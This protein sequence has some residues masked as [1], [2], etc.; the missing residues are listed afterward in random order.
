MLV[1]HPSPS[2]LL[3]QSANPTLQ[4]PLQTLLAH[5]GLAIWLLEQIAPH[6]LQLFLSLVVLISQ[7][8]VCLLPLQSAKPEAQAPLQKPPE[9]LTV[10]ML[11]DEHTVPQPPQFA[12]LVWVLISQPSV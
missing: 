3:L 9:Q 1:S 2:L 7:P 12:A 8:S 10:A 11:L 4:L 5:C 6:A